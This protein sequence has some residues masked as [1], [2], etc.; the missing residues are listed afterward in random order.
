MK[1]KKVNLGCASTLLDGYI[2]VDMDSIDD[3]KKRYPNLEIPTNADFIQSSIFDLPFE[4]DSLDEIRADCV[5]EH[6]S[7][8][9]E[10]QFFTNIPKFL[11]KGGKFNLSTPD[12]E[13]IVK[14]WLKAEDQWKDFFRDDEEAIRNCHWFGTYTYEHKNRWGQICASI[15]GPQNS[16]GQ[17]HKNAYTEAKLIAIYKRMRFENISVNRYLWK[18]ERETIIRIEGTKI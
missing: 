13:I 6:L 18:G 4:E 16:E 17:F 8:K 10:K 9:E 7:F 15:F 11:K 1:M 3:I 2:N 12:F 5:I 14:T